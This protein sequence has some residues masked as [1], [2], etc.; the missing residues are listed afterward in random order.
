MFRLPIL[1]VIS[2]ASLYI[3]QAWAATDE[4]ELDLFDRV[5]NY[6]GIGVAND[7]DGT[8]SLDR[9]GKL[10]HKLSKAV[11]IEMEANA[12]RAG[13]QRQ[14]LIGLS[15]IKCTLKMK[16]WLPGR[17]HSYAGDPA[18]GQG[19]LE[20]ASDIPGYENMTGMQQFNAQVNECPCSTRC[21]KGLA[22]VKCS[23][24]LFDALP[25]RCRNF[26]VQIQKEVHKIKGLNDITSAK[27]AIKQTDKGK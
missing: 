25:T 11:L 8:V 20:P 22:N 26:R 1:V 10:P 15:K 9:K 5:K 7:Y 19:P 12:Q 27:E 3:I 2:L 17:C 6:W 16:K 21:L 24:Q 18:T 4:E 23:K 14:C 13:C